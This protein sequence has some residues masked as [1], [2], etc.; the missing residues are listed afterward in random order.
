MTSPFVVGFHGKL[1]ARGDFVGHGLPRGVLEPWDRWLS[2]ALAEAGRRLG[3]SWEGLF[4]AAPAWR[5]ALAPGLCGSLPLAGILMPSSDRVGRLY[6][7]TIAAALP[8]PMA[9]AEAPVACA[10]W[11]ARA[12]AVAADACRGADVEGLPA[13][14]AILGPPEP[15]RPA[16]D[17]ATV[18]EAL[19]GGPLPEDA[20]LWWTRGGGC[21]APSFLA[22]RG[23]PGSARFAAL[24][25]GAWTRWGWQDVDGG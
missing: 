1:P 9:L 6:P 24:L 13:R 21:V 5:F 11:F 8:R 17:P 16:A 12:E 4:A 19:A 10:G 7:L 15:K 25:D 2:T 3:R 14:L 22:C 20:S 18:V 23:L